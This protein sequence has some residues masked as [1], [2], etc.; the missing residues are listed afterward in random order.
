MAA[1][2]KKYSIGTVQPDMILGKPVFSASGTVLLSEGAIL[3]TTIIE[4]LKHF[5]ILALDILEPDEEAATA[6]PSQAFNRAFIVRHQE[7]V[8]VLY[9]IF[10]DVRESKHIPVEELDALAKD[11]LSLVVDSAG[12]IACLAMLDNKDRYTFIHS[13]NVGITAGIIGKWF[14]FDQTRLKE[15]IFAGFLHDIGKTQVPLDILN[16]PGKLTPE[17]LSIIQKHSH[18][19]YQLISKNQHIPFETKLAILQH[20]E[21]L[22]GTGYPLR[23]TSDRISQVAQII[24]IAD[25]Y[26]ALTSNRVYR[27]G[28]TPFK[29]IKIL[30]DEMFSGKIAP[31]FGT[32]FIS[33]LQETLVGANVQLST[34]HIGKVVYINRIPGS[35]PIIE[36][37]DGQI[38]DLNEH[39]T[40]HITKLL[41][42]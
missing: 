30:C 33:Y 21:K 20:H 36:T 8:D 32:F 25:I 17:E 2:I 10:T 7:T 11:S 15:L 1:I 22:D 18:L 26:D 38:I 6:S 35:G 41:A 12:V 19:G 40:I 27:K 16:K 28:L 24:S 37:T 29:A 5:G 3:G 39:N 13:A 14:G 9:D 42:Q 23:I 31:K 34:G 4:R